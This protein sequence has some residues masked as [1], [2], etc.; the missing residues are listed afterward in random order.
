MPQNEQTPEPLGSVTEQKEKRPFVVPQ[1]LIKK[2]EELNTASGGKLKGLLGFLRSVSDDSEIDA[3]LV[4]KEIDRRVLLGLLDEKDRDEMCAILDGRKSEKSEEKTDGQPEKETTESVDLLEQEIESAKS[5]DELY[6]ILKNSGG[7]DA[8]GHFYKPEELI[9]KI[10][11]F[12]KYPNNLALIGIT[13]EKGL[14]SKVEQLQN[15]YLNEQNSAEPEKEK[16]PETITP[17]NTPA[18]PPSP[19]EASPAGTPPEPVAT[20]PTPEAVPDVETV[21]EQARENYANVLI[22]YKNKHREHKAWY[23]KILSDLG[24][25]KS[26]HDMPVPKGLEDLRATLGDAENNYISAKKEKARKIFDTQT[27][28]EDIKKVY[29]DYVVG[30]DVNEEMADALYKIRLIEQAEKEWDTLQKKILEN[31]PPKEAGKIRRAFAVWQRVPLKVR[32]SLS[33]VVLPVLVGTA[34]VFAM[35]ATAVGGLAV[36]ASVA[37]L[38]SA[39]AIGGIVG[40]GLAGKGFDMVEN[41]TIFV[42][43]TIIFRPSKNNLTP[44]VR[45]PLG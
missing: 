41:K 20:P 2:V 31:T 23:Q 27:T 1:E 25:E 19:G 12:R 24:F 43:A 9:Q 37:G 16:T 40:S 8:H 7:F 5:F 39:R 13:K 6:E 26:L 32:M 45:V 29:P 18:T 3:K 15:Q 35:P 42:V 36:G 10:E 30:Q 28:E 38:R 17:P 14:R 22:E 44:G 34:A 11:T 21:L 4:K 33:V